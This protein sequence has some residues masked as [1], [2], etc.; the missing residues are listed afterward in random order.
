MLNPFLR[1]DYIKKRVQLKPLKNGFLDM[2]NTRCR[3]CNFEETRTA[4]VN[5]INGA[6]DRFPIFQTGVS[7][8]SYISPL[9]NIQR[10]SCHE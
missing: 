1:D 9:T 2:L 10:N 7:K 8:R 4:P 5:E 3:Q 6:R